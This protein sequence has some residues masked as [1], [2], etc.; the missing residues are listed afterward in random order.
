MGRGKRWRILDELKMM[1]LMGTEMDEERLQYCYNYSMRVESIGR[2]I[3]GALW[4]GMVVGGA[5]WEVIA[6]NPKA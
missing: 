6:W 3:K 5:S 1:G 4:I 2:E